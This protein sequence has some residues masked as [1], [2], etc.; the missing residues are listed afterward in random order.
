[1]IDDHAELE[2]SAQLAKAMGEPEWSVKARYYSTFP[3]EYH[4]LYDVANFALVWRVLDWFASNGPL[5]Q[6]PPGKTISPNTKF[7]NWWREADLWEEEDAQRLIL[8]KILELVNER[9]NS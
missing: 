6:W 5:S 1:M 7:R 3:T 8:D 2:K 4:N 9:E